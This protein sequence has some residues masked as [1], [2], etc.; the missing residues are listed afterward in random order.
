MVKVQG[1]EAYVGILKAEP[2]CNEV[3][4]DVD[5]VTGWINGGGGVL[6]VS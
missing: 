4:C 5:R 2:Q 1:V 3:F 6:T